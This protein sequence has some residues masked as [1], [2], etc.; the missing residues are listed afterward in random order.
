M[1]H[2]LVGIDYSDV[3]PLLL[4]QAE[5]LAGATGAQIT[6]LHVVEPEPEF[7]GFEPGP[8]VVR[9]AVAQDH[10]VEHDKL[11]ALKLGL[12]GKGFLV[13]AL[14]VQGVAADKILKEATNLGVN[15][16][17]LGS[18]GHG[19]LFHLLVGGV[20]EA[21][22]KRATCPVLIVPAPSRH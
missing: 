11:V 5:K 9:A 16:I 4:Q 15:L 12:I 22:L 17:V 2:I 7:V 6:L 1:K 18:H 3:T 10:K 21:V 13:N 19:A 8:D 14:Q 20:T